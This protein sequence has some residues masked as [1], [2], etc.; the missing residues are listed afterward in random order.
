VTV[1]ECCYLMK[2]SDSRDIKM[3][4][5]KIILLIEVFCTYLLRLC[6]EL[7]IRK[8]GYWAITTESKAGLQK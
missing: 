6:P 7:K 2:N 4:C 1:T 8:L 5:A 3:F